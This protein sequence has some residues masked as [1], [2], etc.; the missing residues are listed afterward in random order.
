[1]PEAVKLAR[2][3]MAKVIGLGGVFLKSR[4]PAALRA[5]YRDCLGL[6]IASWGGAILPNGPDTFAVWNAFAADTKYFDPSPHH[7]MINLQV[8]DLAAL[9][10]DLRVKCPDRLLD[11]GETTAEGAFGYVLDPDGTLLELYQPAPQA[12]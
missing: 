6:D 2:T 4:D 7:V 8:D 11:R 9:L 10:A 1:M 12:P 5:W 3:H